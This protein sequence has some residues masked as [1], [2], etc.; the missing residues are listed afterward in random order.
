MKQKS[1]LND[2]FEDPIGSE[3]EDTCGSR[4]Q[5][6]SSV[7]NT[8]P[9]SQDHNKHMDN[10]ESNGGIFNE[11]VTKDKIPNAYAHLFVHL[12]KEN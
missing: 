4:Y 7:K 5:V 10:S 12:V 11:Q 9:D 8:E 2:S 6:D 3:G 1:N